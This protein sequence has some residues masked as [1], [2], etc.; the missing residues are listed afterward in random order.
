MAMPMAVP[1]LWLGCRAAAAHRLTV[2]NGERGTNQL[3]FTCTRVLRSP[4]ATTSRCARYAASR[5]PRTHTVA[6]HATLTHCCPSPCQP[7]ASRCL[8]TLTHNSHTQLS[9]RLVLVPRILLGHGRYADRIF[10]P[11]RERSSPMR[12][13]EA[14]G[15]RAKGSLIPLHGTTL[16]ACPRAK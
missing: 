4:K 14:W 15:A 12:C 8:A 11:A 16:A 2:H 6:S 7:S 5:G 1:R 13:A 9:C 10:Q 3:P